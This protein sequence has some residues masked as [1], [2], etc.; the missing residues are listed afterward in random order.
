MSDSK[1]EAIRFFA[2]RVANEAVSQDHG[3]M[4]LK[5]DAL[6]VDVSWFHQGDALSVVLEAGEQ[7]REVTLTLESEGR[8]EQ[9][10]SAVAEVLSEI[11]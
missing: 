3:H 9:I 6:A 7:E 5:R 10:A 4:P 1:A 11:A 2:E 8:Q